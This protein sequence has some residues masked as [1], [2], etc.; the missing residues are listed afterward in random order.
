MVVLE[1]VN[2]G[3]GR[4]AAPVPGRG[5]A[6]MRDR[7]RSAGGDLHAGPFEGG[8]RVRATLPAEVRA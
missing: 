3:D 7:A 6:N 1:V 5:L 4:F 2:E 8:F